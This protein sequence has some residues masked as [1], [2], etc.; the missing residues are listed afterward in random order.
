MYAQSGIII[1]AKDS[2]SARMKVFAKIM[3]LW[4]EHKK[5]Q[6]LKS[7]NEVEPNV[8]ILKQEIIDKI[9]IKNKKTRIKK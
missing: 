7:F 5:K 4:H 6:L 2:D 9:K 3:Q 8:F 1:T